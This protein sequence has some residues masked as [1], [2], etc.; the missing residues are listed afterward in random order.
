LVNLQSGAHH[1]YDKL[2]LIQTVKCMFLKW[3]TRANKK[4]CVQPDQLPKAI[5]TEDNIVEY[6]RAC[7]KKLK[8]LSSNLQ[9][10][11]LPEVCLLCSLSTHADRLTLYLA[12]PSCYY[13]CIPDKCWNT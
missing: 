6:L 1:L 2:E 11:E 7:S 3:E 4:F 12:L 10:K 8:L 5:V 9:G 13:C